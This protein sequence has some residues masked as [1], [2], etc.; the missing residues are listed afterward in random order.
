ML[1]TVANIHA[2]SEQEE[3]LQKTT[4]T[5]KKQKTQSGSFDSSSFAARH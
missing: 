3:N 2:A 4:K 1:I 5:K